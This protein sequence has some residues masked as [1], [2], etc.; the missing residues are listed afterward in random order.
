MD[1]ITKLKGVLYT[2]LIVFVVILAFFITPFSDDLRSTLFP[3]VAGA[4]IIFMI[5]GGILIYMSQKQK[6]KLKSFL[7]LTGFSAIMPL[8]G[9]VL[10][11]VFYA[12]AIAFDNLRFLFE[13]LHGAF[14]IIALVVAPITFI[15]GAI[16][17]MIHMKK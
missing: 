17:S 4:G 12:L 3:M 6:G 9:S 5:L 7:L 15:I 10:H 2:S 16:G 1:K 14:F 13:F 8:A 11:N